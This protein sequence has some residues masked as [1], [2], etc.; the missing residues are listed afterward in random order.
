MAMT[1]T[2]D[3]TDDVLDDPDGGSEAAAGTEYSIDE[4][5]AETG[6]PSRT[7]RYYQSK[8]TLPSPERR[9]RVAVYT[10]EHVERLRTIAELQARGLR[11][12]AI[13]EV[14]ELVAEGGDSL[15]EW[16]GVG[17]RLQ[18]A[19]IEDEPV[20]LSHAELLERVGAGRQGL[21]TELER[22]GMVRR[23]GNS[24]PP[25]YLVVSARLLDIALRMDAIDIDLVTA[26]KAEEILRNRLHKAA[27]ELVEWFSKQLGQGFGHGGDATA[28]ADA[29]DALRPVGIE[30]VQLIFAQ[31]MERS[32][33][34]FVERG[35]VVSG[36]RK[37][38][39][40]RESGKA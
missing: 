34:S 27:D 32:L 29:I 31:E 9:G 14:L 7:I 12:D 17:D 28:V 37:A 5:A 26:Q 18:T 22:V 8:G 6:V 19:W 39:E 23:Q 40:S 16:L 1:S 10:D 38:R 25:T 3:A 30:A 20:V 24:R 35:G 33:R 15:G 4:L 2:D 13:R 21:I 11:L 36:A